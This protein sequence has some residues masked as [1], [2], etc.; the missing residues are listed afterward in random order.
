[1]GTNREVEAQIQGLQPHIQLN[2][3]VV[4]G[5]I[6]IDNMHLE[7]VPGGWVAAYSMLLHALHTAMLEILK[8]KS[9]IEPMVKIAHM[10]P[11]GI[12]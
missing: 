7:K 11:K 2:L 8:E 1:M 10:A 4:D 6:M 5:D 12:C 9:G 3:K